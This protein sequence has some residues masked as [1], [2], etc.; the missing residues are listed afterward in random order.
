[1]SHTV[2]P[3]TTPPL[4]L[5][6]SRLDM[7]ERELIYSQTR[8]EELPEHMTTTS[9]PGEARVAANCEKR[10]RH[11]MTGKANAWA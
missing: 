8:S 2:T 11:E 7:T 9:D 6:L 3:T 4:F 5:F 10:R 1:M